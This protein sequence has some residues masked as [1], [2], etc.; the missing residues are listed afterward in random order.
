MS[1]PM[2]IS[3]SFSYLIKKMRQIFFVYINKAELVTYLIFNSQPTLKVI[4]QPN[5]V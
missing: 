5:T 1:E 4:S 3:F 2:K